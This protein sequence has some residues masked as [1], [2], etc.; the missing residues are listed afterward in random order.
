MGAHRLKPGFVARVV[1]G[2]K[3]LQ[4]HRAVD[5]L[6]VERRVAAR[7]GA[8]D[9]ESDYSKAVKFKGID[10][11]G[12]VTDEPQFVVVRR[13]GALPVSPL[14]EGQDPEPVGQVARH[15]IPGS[16]VLQIRMQEHHWWRCGVAPVAVVEAQPVIEV[17]RLVP[18]QCPASKVLAPGSR[19][20]SDCLLHR[21]L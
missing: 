13:P 20:C 5:A 8:A 19:M 17:D 1:A 12:Q 3:A 4:E 14:V 7:R 6:R 16:R 18:H 10:E 2:R 11:A 21:L 9:R 15:R